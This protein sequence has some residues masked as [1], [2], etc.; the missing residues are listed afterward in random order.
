MWLNWFLGCVLFLFP[1]RLD[2]LLGQRLLLPL[3]IYWVIGG[4][5]LL[6][7]AWQSVVVIRQQLGSTALIF[8]ALMAEIPVVLLTITLIYLHSDLRPMWRA[9]LWIGDGYMLLLGAWYVFL[10]R[11]LSVEKASS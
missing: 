4:G 8:A 2:S 6:F 7:A 10:A 3:L 9:V 5:F 1:S 11:W